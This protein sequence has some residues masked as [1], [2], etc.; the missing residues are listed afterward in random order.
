MNGS[1]SESHLVVPCLCF[2]WEPVQRRD[3]WDSPPWLGDLTIHSA[4]ITITWTWS[5]WF[6]AYHSPPT[7]IITNQVTIT[8]HV[9]SR[10]GGKR[11]V[12]LNGLIKIQLL[13]IVQ[14]CGK[15]LCGLVVS[16]D[17]K[18]SERL[19][20]S[21]YSG[22]WVFFYTLSLKDLFILL[23]RRGT[24]SFSIPNTSC[25]YFPAKILLWVIHAT[26]YPKNEKVEKNLG[27]I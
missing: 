11:F 24:L 13:T 15:H 27:L 25:V 26:V 8:T 10:P 20:R 21:F 22:G 4:V 17:E 3:Y 18:F 9:F 12:C 19:A 6:P 14:A 16:T 2:A 1:R 5:W 23:R 7:T